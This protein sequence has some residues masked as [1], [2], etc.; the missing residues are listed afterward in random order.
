MAITFFNFIFSFK[1]SFIIVFCY[2][3]EL[4]GWRLNKKAHDKTLLPM[5]IWAF[6]F[7]LQSFFLKSKFLY[8]VIFSRLFSFCLFNLQFWLNLCLESQTLSMTV[9]M[10]NSLVVL[11]CRLD[12]IK[13]LFQHWVLVSIWKDKLCW[14]CIEK[15]SSCKWNYS[16]PMV[17]L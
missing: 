8:F 2:F 9:S 5:D 14:F 10:P 6:V 12:F 13:C 11:K 17:D 1:V 7:L 4:T 16:K 15:M 3:Q